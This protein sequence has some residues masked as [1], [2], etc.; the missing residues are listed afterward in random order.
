MVS[1]VEALTASRTRSVEK[2]RILCPSVVEV[3]YYRKRLPS[4]SFWWSS[5]IMMSTAEDLPVTSD[6]FFQKVAGREDGLHIRRSK[7]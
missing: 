5:G 2:T 7:S 6:L 1:M 4:Q 3:S